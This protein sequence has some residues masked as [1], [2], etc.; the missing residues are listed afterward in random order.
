MLQ[1]R[2]VFHPGGEDATDARRRL[3]DVIV[4]RSALLPCQLQ[5]IGRCQSSDPGSNYRDSHSASHPTLT[6][7]CARDYRSCTSACDGDISSNRCNATEAC[8][9]FHPRG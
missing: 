2:A 5:F 8:S 4:D 7:V 1:D 9:G 6:S 3:I